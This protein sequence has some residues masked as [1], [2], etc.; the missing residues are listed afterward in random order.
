MAEVSDENK[1]KELLEENWPEDIYMRTK[2]IQGNPLKSKE[3][4][5]VLVNEEEAHMNNGIFKL[6]KERF[7][8]LVENQENRTLLLIT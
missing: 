8:E 5:A 6:Y 1:L 7:L 4:T 2:I 3:D